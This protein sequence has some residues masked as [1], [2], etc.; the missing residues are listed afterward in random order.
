MEVLAVKLALQIFLKNQNFTSVYI[1]IDNIVALTYFKKMG[2]TKNYKMTILSK[3][4]LEML[5][6]KQIII[7]VE[8]LPSSL[9]KLADL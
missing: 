9:N 7:T 2:R 5:I 4:I 6:S 1:Q 8:Y 3:E